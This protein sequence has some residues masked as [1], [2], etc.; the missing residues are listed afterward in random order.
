[1]IPYFSLSKIKQRQEE[2]RLPSLPVVFVKKEEKEETYVPNFVF[3]TVKWRLF[4][5][6]GIPAARSS[7]AFS[8]SSKDFAAAI[9]FLF[10]Q[11][12]ITNPL[13]L[14]LFEPTLRTVNAVEKWSKNIVQKLRDL[15]RQEMP[16]VNPFVADLGEKDQSVYPP[17]DTA[18]ILYGLYSERLTDLLWERSP[19]PFNDIP[20]R[21]HF[22]RDSIIE[23]WI[24]REWREN[25]N[26]PK[27]PD[28]NLTMGMDYMHPRWRLNG[29]FDRS[30]IM[31]EFLVMGYDYMLVVKTAAVVTIEINEL[32]MRKLRLHKKNKEYDFG[33]Y[34]PDRLKEKLK[35]LNDTMWFRFWLNMSLSAFVLPK[36]V[37][38]QFYRFAVSTIITP[39]NTTK[40]YISLPPLPLTNSAVSMRIKKYLSLYGV[41]SSVDIVA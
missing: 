11:Q 24:Y 27:Y 38:G 35:I 31:G 13:F 37:G 41:Q 36:E 6:G 19:D 4:I 15:A 33:A 18:G 3:Y 20:N 34:R 26:F 23:F 9:A 7:F 8:G 30:R 40:A 29:S 32:E 10:G 2:F 1:M 14:D 25:I 22:L 16:Q 17:F 39:S 12:S 5:S 21:F 28:E